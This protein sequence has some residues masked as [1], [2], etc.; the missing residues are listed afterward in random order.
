M[1]TMLDLAHFVRHRDNGLSEIQLAL[2]AI[3]RRPD[4]AAAEGA[5]RSLP[6][7][8]WVRFNLERLRVTVRWMRADTDPAS[9]LDALEQAG[10][11]AYPLEIG[12][13]TDGEEARQARWLLSC[14]AIAGFA[15]MNIMLLSVSVWAGNITD[16]TP[17]TRDV[18][19]WLSALIALPAAAYAGQPFFRS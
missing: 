3:G 17:E 5:V 16:I 14:L 8:R 2:E 12:A 19:H 15:A 7:V 1:E 13:P 11:R 18:F 10:F 4:I 6:G 9:L